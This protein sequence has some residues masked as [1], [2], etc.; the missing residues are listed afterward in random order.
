MLHLIGMTITND[1]DLFRLRA[2]INANRYEN[3]P[4]E[5]KENGMERHGAGW[6]PIAQCA[7][8]NWELQARLSGCDVFE[9]SGRISFPKLSAYMST[10]LPAV[11]DF[12]DTDDRL[13]VM[14]RLHLFM[15]LFFP[16]GKQM[17]HVSNQP[18]HILT[19]MQKERGQTWAHQLKWFLAKSYDDGRFNEERAAQIRRS[20]NNRWETS[21]EVAPIKVDTS[22]KIVAIPSNM[23]TEVAIP[24]IP[25]IKTGKQFPPLPPATL[26]MYKRIG[27]ELLPG[28]DPTVD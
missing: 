28:Q 9:S 20:F 26:A 10:M 13:L 12:I 8:G 15:R 3:D 21:F 25:P 2:F 22:P 16:F 27:I 5:M 19:Q 4:K 18:L 14:Y 11:I 24:D 7:F 17:L 23:P 1:D 6:N